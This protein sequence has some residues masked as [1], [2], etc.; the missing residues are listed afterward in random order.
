MSEIKDKI[1]EYINNLYNEYFRRADSVIQENGIG[2]HDFRFSLERPYPYIR[3]IYVKYLYE[4]GIPLIHIGRH[5]G[6]THSTLSIHLTAFDDNCKY[7][8]EFRELAIDLKR[9]FKQK[10]IENG[11]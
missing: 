1:N 10:E 7:I 4:K 6:M 11:I 2:L 9:K 5:L 8:P 3:T